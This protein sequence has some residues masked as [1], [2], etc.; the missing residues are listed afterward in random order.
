M[1]TVGDEQRALSRGK[2]WSAFQVCKKIYK[3]RGHSDAHA[4]WSITTDFQSPTPDD[5]TK[6]CFRDRQAVSD[7]GPRCERFEAIVGDRGAPDVRVYA[8][9]KIAYE[10]TNATSADAG[11]VRQPRRR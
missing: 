10:P 6:K 11:A 8:Q 7:Q 1:R 5:F 3:S 2:L 4:A 9:I